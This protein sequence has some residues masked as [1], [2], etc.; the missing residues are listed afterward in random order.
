MENSSSPLLRL[1]RRHQRQFA[2]QRQGRFQAR[3]A[4][5]PGCTFGPGFHFIFRTDPAA[6]V[7]HRLP[8]HISRLH[9]GAPPTASAGR[10]TPM[11]TRPPR[12]GTTTENGRDNREG[13]E[14]GRRVARTIAVTTIV[15]TTSTSE[16]PAS[17]FST[18]TTAAMLGSAPHAQGGA[19]ANGG[20]AA[21]NAIPPARLA[22]ARGNNLF[23][24][25]RV[26]TPRRRVIFRSASDGLSDHD[27]GRRSSGPSRP[28]PGRPRL[29]WRP[30][31]KVVRASAS[32]PV[33]PQPSGQA[34]A[35][36]ARRRTRLPVGQGAIT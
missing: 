27:N 9:L 21:S 16:S 10:R 19:G 14:N 35:R 15:V 6:P 8:R 25:S 17:R 30:S 20:N 23:S 24:A 7:R 28:R 36:P 2:G 33:G 4:A 1:N 22:R 34:A 5:P 12:S 32:R 31:V 13:R 18:R 29:P 11:P 3:A 26:C